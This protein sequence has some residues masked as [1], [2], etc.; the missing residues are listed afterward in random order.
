MCTKNYVEGKHVNTYKDI[1]NLLLTEKASYKNDTGIII[2]F[3]RDMSVDNEA[4]N[5]GH[6]SEGEFEVIFIFF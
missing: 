3:V 5:S 2:L 4:V 6:L 1:Q